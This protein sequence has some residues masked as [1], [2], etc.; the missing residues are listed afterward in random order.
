MADVKIN[1]LP[2]QTT[3]SDTDVVIVETATSTN[4]M[5]VGKLKELIGIQG[6]GIV[7]SGSTTHP[8]YTNGTYVKFADGTMICRFS[9]TLNGLGWVWSNGDSIMRTVTFPM[10]FASNEYTA[11]II[12]KGTNTPYGW[13]STPLIQSKVLSSAYI[14]MVATSDTVFSSG[15]TID[16]DVMII[17]RWK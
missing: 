10:P 3:I 5:T 11:T 14:G 15:N 12:K 9:T 8:S 2:E 16:V 6:G 13:K 4:K 7:E 1:Q 17:G